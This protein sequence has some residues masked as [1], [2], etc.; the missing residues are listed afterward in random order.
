MNLNPAPS[1]LHLIELELAARNARTIEILRQRGCGHLVEEITADYYCQLSDLRASYADE[2]SARRVPS[3]STEAGGE[4]AP[5]CKVIAR[6]NAL[7]VIRYDGDHYYFLD[8]ET[9]VEE[10]A[11][12]EKEILFCKERLEQIAEAVR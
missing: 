9:W 6:V 12:H 3:R 5:A 10:P 2:A 7:G 8:R 1:E 11:R 4:L